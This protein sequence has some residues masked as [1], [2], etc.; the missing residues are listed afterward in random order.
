MII[1]LSGHGRAGKDTV[2]KILVDRYD[3]QR[4]AFADVLREVAYAI[5]P[6]IP[7]DEWNKQ[8]TRLSAYVNERGWEQAK[9]ENVEVRWLLQRLGTE[10]GRNVLGE[11]VWINALVDK[12]ESDVDYVITD[13]RFP[14]EAVAVKEELSGH[15][16]R[17]ERP[18]AGL[19]GTAA[20]HASET[21]LDDWTFDYVLNNFG[22][23][24]ALQASVDHMLQAL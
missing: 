21:A 24:D 14:N 23:L 17:V 5:D 19:T 8:F 11:N 1:G 13:V 7:L 22:T 6:Y 9:I 10:A 18:Q 15:V 16:V 2:G 3:F 20:L 12:M 4:L